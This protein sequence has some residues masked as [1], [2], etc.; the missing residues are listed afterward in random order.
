[1]VSSVKAIDRVYRLKSYPSCFLGSDAVTW[2]RQQYRIEPNQAV[3]LGWALQALGM[4]HHVAHEQPFDNTANFFR[5][6]LSTAAERQ[7]LGKLLR[8]VSSKAGFKVKD[9][10]YRGTSY[11]ACFIG[12]E[13]VDFL[14]DKFNINRHD[15]EIILNRLYSFN[16]IEHVTQDHNVRDGLFFYRFVA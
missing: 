8:L 11:P 16:M 14:K 13:A 5:T 4:L 12:S 1:M 9:R 7:P 2:L 6:N 3:Q 15:S 10:S